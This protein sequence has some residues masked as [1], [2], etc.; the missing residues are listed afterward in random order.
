MPQ[1]IEIGA[2]YGFPALLVC[3]L[4]WTQHRRDTTRDERSTKT[5]E[6]IRDVLLDT[7]AH[8]ASAVAE[9]AKA[10]DGIAKALSHNTRHTDDTAE[11]LDQLIAL[12]NQHRCPLRDGKPIDPLETDPQPPE[13][14]SQPTAVNP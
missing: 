10:M 4:L 13:T 1:L 9:N 14:A 3:F 5:D 11:K 7:L 2:Q 12:F 6:F 8:A